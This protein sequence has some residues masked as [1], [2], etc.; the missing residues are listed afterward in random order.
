MQDGFFDDARG[1]YR[2]E[3][4]RVLLF[5]LVICPAIDAGCVQFLWN[6]LVFRPS[7]TAGDR[8]RRRSGAF[9]RTTGMQ[10]LNRYRGVCQVAPAM[11]NVPANLHGSV[12]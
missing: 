6:E 7:K 12:P 4:G 2:L 9:V 5:S 3:C 11:F 8:N 10:K 1:K